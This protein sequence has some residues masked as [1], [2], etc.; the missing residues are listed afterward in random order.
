MFPVKKK[1]ISL[2]YGS[3]SAMSKFLSAYCIVL[4]FVLGYIST[5]STYSLCMIDVL[6]NT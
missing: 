5:I 6:F 2:F 4:T 3:F 1:I